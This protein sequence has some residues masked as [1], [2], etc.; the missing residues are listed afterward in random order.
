VR[1]AIGIIVA[2]VVMSVVTFALSVAPWFVLGLD[3]VLEPGRFDTVR[4]YDLYAL[5]VAFGGAVLGGWL[6]ATIG[7][8]RI[9]VFVLAGFAV[10]G[11]VTN[12]VQ[13]A[14]RPEPGA[15][16]SGVPVQQVMQT[17][18]EPA[19]YTWLIPVLGVTGVLVGGRLR[20][21]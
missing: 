20:R 8:S 16:T 11:G 19:W 1:T 13:Q 7:R 3:A 12:A 9:A 15:R 10:A 2:L 18:R 4:A 14:G 5:A 21:P 6:A 17:R